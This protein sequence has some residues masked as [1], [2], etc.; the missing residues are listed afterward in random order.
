MPSEQDVRVYLLVGDDVYTRDRHVTQLRKQLQEQGLQAQDEERHHAE[1]VDLESIFATART[2]SFWSPRRFLIL[3]DA[4]LLS[5]ESRAHLLGYVEHPSSTT[6]MVIT[7][8]P[9]SGRKSKAWTAWYQSMSQAAIVVNCARPHAKDV[10]QCIRE[11]AKEL[12]ITLSRGAGMA[13]IERTGGKLQAVRDALERLALF[14]GSARSVK[15]EDIER[16]VRDEPEAST[17]D[18][19]DAIGERQT[20]RA[21]SLT[22]RLLDERVSD[23]VAIVGLLAWHL[24]RLQKV[25]RV[26][27]EGGQSPDVAR[28]IRVPPFVARRMIDQAGR[29]TSDELA[30]CF[31]RLLEADLALKGGTTAAPRSILEVMVME[32]CDSKA[33]VGVSA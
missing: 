15:R 13:L 6:C 1:D 20:G 29:Y 32:L 2:P 28:E 17:F 21:L 30:V 9:P 12:N 18:L 4:Q 19:V 24:S 27:Q 3:Y 23:P 7:V 31:E 14:V 11:L 16:L 33:T 26:V 22:G 8:Q 25:Q 10:A 5:E